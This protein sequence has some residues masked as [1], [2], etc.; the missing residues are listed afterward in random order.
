MDN[1]LDICMLFKKD[2]NNGKKVSSQE[3]DAP[4]ACLTFACYR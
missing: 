4:E 1:E 2:D 3:K